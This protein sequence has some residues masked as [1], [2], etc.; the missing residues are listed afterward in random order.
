MELDKGE[1]AGDA[2]EDA[3]GV[4]VATEAVELVVSVLMGGGATEGDATAAGRTAEVMSELKY[5][6]E[7]SATRAANHG[8]LTVTEDTARAS[9]AEGL[10]DG[11]SSE[12]DASTVATLAGSEV[13]TG[14][15][16]GTA[17]AVAAVEAVAH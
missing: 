17:A 16:D 9:A 3:G 6:L 4:A 10:D 14:S 12:E 2:D 7:A 11:D 15:E 5:W 8:S 1:A 13:T